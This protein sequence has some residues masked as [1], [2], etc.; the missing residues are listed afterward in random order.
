MSK[1]F[2]IPDVHLKPWIF[3]KAEEFLARSK[4]D[5][6]VFLGDLVDDWNQETNLGL[7][8]E[9][10][11]AL[12][13]FI[14]RHP[15]FLLCYGNHDVS[16]I[17]EA[18]ESG[19][20]EYARQ[21]VL[22]GISKLEKLIPAGNI[23]YIHRVDNVLF[24]H[25][26]LTEPFVSHYLPNFD[27]DIDELLE[28]INSFRR[29]E[30]WCDASPI[31]TRPQDGRIEMYPKGYLQVVGHTPVRQT[32]YFGE[33][34]TVDN[35]STYRNGTPIG[36]QRFIWVDTVSKQW[37]FADGSGEPENLPDPKLDIRNYKDGDHVKFK[38]RY[39]GSDQEEI[40]EGIVETINQYSGG[41]SSL[42]VMSEDTLYKQ[43]S[44]TD[45]LERCREGEDQS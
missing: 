32:D 20:S 9:T 33:V 38:F 4:Y 14:N 39:Y 10:F 11:D 35:F 13:R 27:S 12:E 43:L 2:V 5:K 28:R 24:S 16:Y 8:S 30:L 37:G 42:D 31:W 26:G 34:V 19:Y 44:L 1:V 15:N 41:Q 40:H 21:V 25:A 36:D 18:H 22:E 23:A 7:Y 3:D 45:V 29:D 6:I 17:W